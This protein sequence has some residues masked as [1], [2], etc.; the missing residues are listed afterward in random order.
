MGFAG[1]YGK[2]DF[3]YRFNMVLSATTNA[4]FAIALPETIRTKYLPAGT[5]QTES[6]GSHRIRLHCCV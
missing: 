4:A 6:S 3:F 1:K 5:R 2:K